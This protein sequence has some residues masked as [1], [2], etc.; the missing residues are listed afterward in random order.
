M[1]ATTPLLLQ[2]PVP[3]EGYRITS[4]LFKGPFRYPVTPKEE[5]ATAAGAEPNGLNNDYL[6]KAVG[7]AELNIDANRFSQ[8]ADPAPSCPFRPWVDHV[9][10]V[11]TLATSERP[12]DY[13]V[14]YAAVQI[15]SDRDQD[16]TIAL[17]ADDSATLWL[18]H[19]MIHSDNNATTRGLMKFSN[20]VGAHFV[21]GRNFLLLKSENKKGNWQFVV[22]VY[23]YAR[24]RDLA[25]ENGVNDLLSSPVVWSN[26]ALRIREDL[27]NDD[28]LVSIAIFSYDGKREL[29]TLSAKTARTMPIW[30]RVPKD[31]LYLCRVTTA[32]RAV[33]SR[34]FWYGDVEAGLQ[35]DRIRASNIV[36]QN[37]HSQIAVAIE[38]QLERI[39]QLLKLENHDVPYWADNV[40]WSLTELED[41]LEGIERNDKD[42]LSLPGT[43]VRGFRSA[44][45]GQFQ[46]Y[47]IHVPANRF[48]SRGPMPLVVVMPYITGSNLPFLQSY[49]LSAYD[50]DQRYELL[51]NEFGFAVLQL[52]G[53]GNFAGGT[54]LEAEDVWETIAAVK[55]DYNIDDRRMYLM[56]YCEGGRRALLLAEH[57]PGKFAALSVEGPITTYDSDLPFRALWDQAMADPTSAS[58]NLINDPVFIL[59][60]PNDSTPFGTSKHF[61]TKCL[62]EGVQIHLQQE[63]G[64]FHGFYQDPFRTKRDLFNFLADKSR[65][66]KPRTLSLRVGELRFASANWLRITGFKEPGEMATITA[67]VHNNVVEVESANVQSLALAPELLPI[68]F[69]GAVYW[70]HRL[71]PTKTAGTR[72]IVL[73]STTDRQEH[74]LAKT[75]DIAGPIADAFGGP[76]L[77]VRPTAGDDAA[78][79]SSRRLAT[80]FCTMWQKTYFAS[81]PMKDDK[82]VTQ[83]DISMKNLVV[84][85]ATINRILRQPAALGVPISVDRSQVS[86]ADK[87]FVG[88]NLAYEVIYPNPVNPRKYVVLIGGTRLEA[89]QPWN[90]RM[91][92][93]GVC[94]YFILQITGTHA[95]LVDAGYF[96][97]S[98]RTLH[99]AA[100]N[101]RQRIE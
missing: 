100:P 39:D 4:W 35:R 88:N 56:G 53:R 10:G 46:Y 86:I 44:I 12:C 90:L 64:G 32:T 70:N 3:R 22:T 67:K 59:H 63:S 91:Q 80:S 5:R 33:T 92:E 2:G 16:V 93:T 14:S 40:T 87:H 62:R 31:H 27:W 41:M 97:R 71:V 78:R 69:P 52:W 55:R 101:Y 47:W 13:E 85:G 94:D 6:L 43:H 29:Q 74:E 38:A 82:D 19:Q 28:P 81:C 73:D 1:L 76:F 24:G 84:F 7:V 48:R 26:E 65:V 51:G 8:V 75:P 61:V 18:N 17:G 83:A 49:F 99:S 68:T 79:L 66:D 15:D 57:F 23:P 30:L 58:T 77:V 45:D 50:E 11:V 36:S 9:S 34:P 72:Q 25:R 96:D 98:W 60:D 21:R 42:I 54:P 37:N 20:V 95:H 89:V